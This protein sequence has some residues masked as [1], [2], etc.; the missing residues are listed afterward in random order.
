[1][2]VSGDLAP[3][4]D[5]PAHYRGLSLQVSPD[6][7]VWWQLYQG[8]DRLEVD[9]VPTD[10]AEATLEVKR[11][12]G[13]I[14]VTEE[15]AV[16]TRVEDE[17]AESGYRGVYVGTVSF[18]E[19]AE[20]VPPEHPEFG[21]DLRP[22]GLSPGDLWPGV[23]D[24]SRYS[25]AGDRVWW[26]NGETSKRHP[27]PDGLPDGVEST[28]ARLKRRG[29][30]FRVLPWGD[31]ITLVPV[32]EVPSG[33]NGQFR[34]LPRVV[35]NVIR[36]R[37]ERGVEML[38]VYVGNVADSSLEVE[39][40]R[41]LA[42]ELTAEE[43]EELASWAGSLGETS[44]RS[45]SDHTAAGKRTATPKDGDTDRDTGTEETDVTAGTG[46]EGTDTGDAVERTA[47]VRDRNEEANTGTGVGMTGTEPEDGGTEPP[48]FEDDPLE[49]MHRNLDGIEEQ[50]DDRHGS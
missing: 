48:E 21:I 40:P 28:L 29:G 35:Q 44:R 14:H 5:W 46:V 30:S 34:D 45:T 9:P 1:M 38:P 18:P 11:I 24:G 4:D 22:S 32:E 37:K 31:V 2:G 50:D 33:A 26:H 20:L 6:G 16:L 39:E 12:G 27:V 17:S 23:Y 43:R 36:L 13:R 7:S 10:V 41:S 19:D 47:A 42:D 3:G 8:T 15:G 25:F 49:W